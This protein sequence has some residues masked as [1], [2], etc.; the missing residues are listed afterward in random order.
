MQAIFPGHF[1]ST[2]PRRKCPLRGGSCLGAFRIGPLRRG[3]S[4]CGAKDNS[5]CLVTH[6]GKCDSGQIEAPRGPLRG[7]KL[8]FFDLL[9]TSG[10]E[11]ANGQ[12]QR[13]DFTP[14]AAR[15]F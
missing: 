11:C 14:D 7:I 8:L 2:S 5:D 4:P 10:R 13:N 15:F 6:C 12:I 9:K 1:G 3:G